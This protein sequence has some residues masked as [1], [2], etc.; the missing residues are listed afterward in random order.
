MA[1]FNQIAE[2]W[3][4]RW[5]ESRIFEATPDKRKKYFINFPY[6]YINSYLHL[7]HAFSVTRVDVSA[8]YK[9]MQGFNVLFPQAWHCTGTPVW[10]AAQRVRENEPKQIKILE[11]LGFEADEIK[12]FSDVKHWIDVFVPAAKEDLQK[13]GAGIDWR[14]S[15]IT[16]DMNPRYDKFIRWQFRKLKEKGFVEKGKHPVVWCPKDQMPV[17]DHDR[18]EGEGETPKEFIWVKFRLKNSDLILMVG[19]T[20]PDALLGQTHI[21]VDPDAVYSIVKVNNEKWVVGKEAIKKIENQHKKPVVIGNITSKELIGKWA[22]GPLVDYELYIVPAW[23]IDANVGSGIVYSAL[24]DPVD[25]VEIQHIQAN[26][27]IVKKYDLDEKVIQKLKPISIINVLGMG[28]NLG[29]EMI[30]KYG[31]KSPKDKKKIDDAKDE[32]NR[33]VFRKGIMKNNCGKYAGLA[34]PHAQAVINKDLTEANDAM[35]F[36]ELTGKVTCRCLSECSIKI[37]SDQWFMQYK[38]PEWKKLTHKCLDNLTLYPDLV[39]Q[40]FNHVID[41]LNDWACTHHHGTGTKLPWDE[42]WVI[43]SLSDSTI[44]MAYYTIAHLINEIPENEIDDEI[45]DFIFLNKKIDFKDKN[46]KFLIQKMKKE[47]EYWYPFDVRSSG[48]DLI[49]NHLTFCLFN[50]TA[51]FPEKY[52]PR[53]FSVNGWLLVEGGKMSKSKGNFFT[54]REIIGLHSADVTRASLM[55]GGEGLSDPNF[56]LKN[57]K[58]LKEKLEQWLNFAK[59]NY[60]KAA[61]K[62]V[63]I[64][65]RIFLSGIH[66]SLK[67][68]TEAMESMLFRS[69]F[70]KLFFQMQRILKGYLKRKDTSQHLINQFIE[71][72]TKVMSPFCP[73]IAEEAWNEIEKKGFVSAEQWPAYNEKM[74]DE[75]AEGIAELTGSARKDIVEI[76]NLAKINAP[77]K[78]TLFVAEKWKY[79]LIK[80]MKKMLEETRNTGEILKKLMSTSL[81]Q[82]AQDISKM[83]PKLVNGINKMPQFDLNQSAEIDALKSAAKNYGEEFK[84]KVEVIS[85]EDSKEPKAKQAMPSKAAIL[86][87]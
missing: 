23:F 15:F 70:E 57:A 69:A 25:L 20:R 58:A 54:I 9:R 86:V 49:Q 36:Y 14:R 68:G 59:E 87:E 76:M 67:E 79:E 22:K 39:R 32:L 41:W 84:C 53:A 83:V 52:W 12:K 45:F 13:L 64:A 43:E 29:Q 21:W 78:I 11:S 44:Y 35:M 50:H 85:A 47:F 8:R 31:I 81:R 80:S 7:G 5:E 46:Q 40:Q 55:I 82:H 2:K 33:I 66:R 71:L 34:V 10:A 38:N 26:P 42:K 72:Q 27:E 1:D 62:E 56:D 51:I 65:D 75:Q 28:E 61:K 18:V 24:E 77:K 63:G 4:K 16:T 30:D 17:G 6:P 37:V 3:Q 48:K 73:F 74:I 60:K 19:T